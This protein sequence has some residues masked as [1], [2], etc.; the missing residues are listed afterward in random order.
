MLSLKFKFEFVKIIIL[1]F[2]FGVQFRLI[3]PK[4]IEFLLFFLQLSVIKLQF[5]D[6]KLVQKRITKSFLLNVF[7]FLI[8]VQFFFRAT[9]LFLNS[10]EQTFIVYRCLNRWNRRR[11]DFEI[12][13]FLRELYLHW[14]NKFGFQDLLVLNL[15]LLLSLRLYFLENKIIDEVFIDLVFPDFVALEDLLLLEIFGLGEA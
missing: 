4:I 9:L 13:K 6:K 11:D 12:F 1:F 14:V 2:D 7:D 8:Q 10:F 15:F 3:Q 5:G